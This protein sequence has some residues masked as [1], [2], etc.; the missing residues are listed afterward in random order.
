MEKV[1]IASNVNCCISYNLF[2][3]TVDWRVSNLSK[4]LLEVAVQRRVIIRKAGEWSINTHSTG[5]LNTITCHRKNHFVKVFVVPCKGTVKSVAFFLCAYRNLFVWNLKVC[6]MKKILI[7]PFT[8]RILSCICFFKF[9][10]CNKALLS[11]INK[12]HAARHKAALCNN[13]IFRNIENTN[14]ARKN[15]H[16]IFCN[17]VAARAKTITVESCTKNITVAVKNC[18]RSIP[19]FH[20]SSPV[21]IE[22]ALFLSKAVVVF[23]RFRNTNHNS[24]RKRH[25]VH[26]KI[27]ESVVE[28]CRV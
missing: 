5:W 9:F 6:K 17:K 27:F 13:L 28:H 8:I 24:K 16:I 20:H 11:S 15:Q 22:V 1:A 23:P 2:A 4:Q 12:K 25:T 18:G 10:I 26:Y 14:F 19:R 3:Q 7:K 21:V